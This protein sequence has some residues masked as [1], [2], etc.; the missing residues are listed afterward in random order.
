MSY[1]A[2]KAILSGILIAA[3]SEIA[4]RSPGFAAL[5]ASL[6]LVSILGMVW[7]WRDTGDT[8]RLASHAEATFWYVLPSLPMF[9]IVPRLMRAE[10][11]FWVALAAGCAVTVVLY[12]LLVWLA[13]RFDLP[14]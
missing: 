14:I 13:P 3:I 6:A 7:L 2:L 12:L 5:V 1:F 9:L 11:S 10:V 4:R 8:V